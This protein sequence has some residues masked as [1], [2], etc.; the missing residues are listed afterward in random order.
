MSRQGSM[1]KLTITLLI[2]VVVIFYVI[3]NTRLLF[4]GPEI[5][6]YEL[7]NGQKV[8]EGL[9][10]IKGKANDISFISLNGRQIFIDENQ[11]FSEKVLLTNKVNVVEIYAEDK[12]GKKDL[13]ELTLIKESA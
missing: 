6:I 8:T 4:R 1:F 2:S 5:T 7:T 9:V 11:M 12:F 10:E 13:E 3:F